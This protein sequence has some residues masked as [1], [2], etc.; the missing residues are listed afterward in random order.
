MENIPTFNLCD[1]LTEQIFDLCTIVNNHIK[2]LEELLKIKKISKNNLKQKILNL[3][4]NY[5][6]YREIIK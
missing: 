1:I 4:E 3:K 6:D 2:D 5:K